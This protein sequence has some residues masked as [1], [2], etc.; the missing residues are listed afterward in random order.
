MKSKEKKSNPL[1]Q[2][3]QRSLREWSRDCSF[4]KQMCF[5]RYEEIRDNDLSHP[6][7]DP[8]V[9]SFPNLSDRDAF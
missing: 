5:I 6:T 2:T 4:C 8:D 3:I 7:S 1:Q 9:A